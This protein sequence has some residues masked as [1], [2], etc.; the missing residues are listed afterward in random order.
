[1]YIYLYVYNTNILHNFTAVYM[2][3]E[4][5]MVYRFNY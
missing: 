3:N 1:M 5:D 4:C 2:D